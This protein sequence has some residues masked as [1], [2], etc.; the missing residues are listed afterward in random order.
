MAIILECK[1]SYEELKFLLKKNKDELMK[2]RI[3]ILLLIKK[4]VSRKEI[5]ERL[6][7]N[8]G[9]ITNVVK[10]YNQNGLESLRTNKGGRPEG[11]PLWDDNIFEGLVKEIEKQDRY[12]SLPIMKEWI[13]KHYQK[14]ISE[15]TV[16]Y[17]M[18][19]MN[20]MSYKSSR[21]HPYLGDKKKACWGLPKVL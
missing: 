10:R 7:V 21:P 13:Q 3:K 15:K 6:S 16:W 11:N 20:Q 17:R 12:W 1:N 18:R 4:D 19:H 5:S 14:A 9:T 2:S 8:K